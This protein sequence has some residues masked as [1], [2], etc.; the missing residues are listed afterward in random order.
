ML[1]I[2]MPVS[3][4]LRYYS[5]DMLKKADPSAVEYSGK[6]GTQ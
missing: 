3:V 6:M 1:V 4:Y 5:L 2:S